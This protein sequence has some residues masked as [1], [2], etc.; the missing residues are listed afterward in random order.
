MTT[1]GSRWMASK[2]FFWKASPESVGTNIF[3]ASAMALLVYSGVTGSLAVSVSSMRTTNSEML[4]SQA[5]CAWSMTSWKSSPVFTWPCSRSYSR[6]SMLIRVLW[7]RRRARRRVRSFSRAGES[8]FVGN[9]LELGESIFEC[10]LYSPIV[11]GQF[12]NECGR[13][14][15][16]A[17]SSG[18][19]QRVRRET[20]REISRD[21]AARQREAELE[22]G[23]PVAGAGRLS[24]E[25]RRTEDFPDG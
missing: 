24:K 4:W 20:K 8:L 13:K 10:H 5:N 14:S 9:K 11:G 18:R 12:Q 2:Y 1:A 15:A 21:S 6:R 19:T 3:R 16:L 25:C 17:Q 7:R 23:C 22:G